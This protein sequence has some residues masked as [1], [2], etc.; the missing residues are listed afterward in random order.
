[1]KPMKVIFIFLAAIAMSCSKNDETTPDQTLEDAARNFAENTV[2]IQEPAGLKNS[3]DTY[4]QLASSWI[5]TAN[6]LSNYAAL[7]YI[8]NSAQKTNTPIV[9]SNGRVAKTNEE[10]LIYQWEDQSSSN[11]I[12]YQIH[13]EADKYVYE[14]FIK[15]AGHDGWIRY[16]YAEA[17]KNHEKALLTIFNLDDGSELL[18]YD[19]QVVDNMFT[20]NFSSAAS[21]SLITLDINTATGTGTVVTFYNNVKTYDMTWDSLGNG[22]WIYYGT[23]GSALLSGE[24]TA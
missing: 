7:F 24:W 16:M 21:S 4:A 5:Q 17:Q 9:A 2:Q 8:P 3:T 12:A 20:M 6:S 14:Y 18:N 11:G 13:A 23:D 22:S 15:T 10:Y 19:W 1:M